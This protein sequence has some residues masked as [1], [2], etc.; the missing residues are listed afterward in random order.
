MRLDKAKVVQPEN[1]AWICAKEELP[2]MHENW[3]YKYLDNHEK[4]L[5]LH[6]LELESLKHGN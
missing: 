3:Q 5:L 4:L 6:A 1:W 2:L